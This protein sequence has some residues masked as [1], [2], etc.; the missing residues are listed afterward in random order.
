MIAR[1]RTPRKVRVD[2]ERRRSPGWAGVAL[3]AAGAIAAAA[4]VQNYRDAS[5][6]ASAWEAKLGELKRMSQRTPS[7]LAA[8]ARDPAEVRNEIRLANAVLQ[9]IALP[10]DGLF[11]ELE[12]TRDKTISLL[13]VQPDMQNRVVRIG[14]EAKSLRSAVEY[15]SRLDATAVFYNVYLSGH[16]VRTQDP[17]RPV[18]FSLVASWR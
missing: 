18:S 7:T 12:R 4:A 10:W 1:V 15:A 17:Q 11:V 9:Q 5:Q 13:S 6:Q 14:G 8:A 16:E 3:A 2:F